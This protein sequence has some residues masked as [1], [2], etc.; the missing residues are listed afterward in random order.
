MDPND[1]AVL[2]G[3]SQYVGTKATPNAWT[4]TGDPCTA[5]W[6]GVTCNSGGF[7]TAINLSS[8][9]LAGKE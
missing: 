8:R 7:V 6:S 5:S 9:A 1:K 4:S 3:L 2:Q